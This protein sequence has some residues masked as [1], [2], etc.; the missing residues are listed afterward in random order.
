[1][2]KETKE[3]HEAFAIGLGAA[4]LAFAVL[5]AVFEMIREKMGI[6]AIPLV[7]LILW[8][9]YVFAGIRLELDGFR[10]KNHSPP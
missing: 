4:A 9:E 6:W 1:M 8:R 2:K 3:I 10:K 7:A 5:L